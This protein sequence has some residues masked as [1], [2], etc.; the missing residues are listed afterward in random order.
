[1][2]ETTLTALLLTVA[3][4][5]A[6]CRLD[7]GQTVTAQSIAWLE[8][9]RCPID[10]PASHWARLAVRR[11]RCGRDIPDC[12]VSRADALSRSVQG[13]GMGQVRDGEPTPDLL[14]A[15]REAMAN[16]V[17]GM[18]DQAA[19]VTHLR[20][21]GV[22]NQEIAAELGVSPARISQIARRVVERFGRE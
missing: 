5:A 6:R 15:D 1:M 21:S 16:L 9:S 4:W 17:A 12:A 19:K 20:L 10:Y 18:D 8:A 14:A 3:N 2:T 11:V 13:C 7:E 22:P